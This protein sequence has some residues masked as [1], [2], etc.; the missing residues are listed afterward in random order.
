MLSSLIAVLPLFIRV[1]SSSP[2]AAGGA[3]AAPTNPPSRQTGQTPALGWNTWNAYRCDIN[4]Q[5]VVAAAQAFVDRGLKAAG[6]QYI[7][8]DDCWSLKSRDSS[9]KRIVPDPAKFPDGIAGVAN[10]VH[11]LGLK[12]GIYS[13][14][15]TATCAGYP[16]SLANENLDAATFSSWGIDY[17]KYDNCNIPA[18]WTDAP[19]PPNGD[20]YESN[21][22]IRFRLMGGALAAQSRPIQYN[23]CIW[24]QAKVQTWGNRVGHSWRISGDSSPTWSFILSVLKLNIPY[25]SVNNFYSHNDMDMMEIGNGLSLVEERSHFAIWAFL[26]SPILLGTDLSKLSAAQISIITNPEL[27]AFHQD[28]TVGPSALPFNATVNA[29][30]TDPP[31]YY[32]GKSSKGTHVLII[33]LQNT[34]ATKTVALSQVPGLGSGTFKLHDMWTGK[35]LNGTYTAASSFSVQVGSHDNVAYRITPA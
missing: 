14:A 12:I 18:N 17:L 32:A 24:G 28:T 4:A 35:D 21:S 26:K 23:L 30:V 22:G 15:G 7:N 10:T 31:E 9:S 19:N 20:W 13:D 1:A 29:P 11:S 8:I 25:L 5:K 27:L 6:Y 34:T 3:L 33:N 16:G 2:A